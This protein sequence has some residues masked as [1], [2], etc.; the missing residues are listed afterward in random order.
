MAKGFFRVLV[1]LSLAGAAGRKKLNGIHRFL[2]EGYDW[3]MELVRDEADFTEEVL[4]NA[5]REGFNGVFVGFGER[6]EMKR[7]HEKTG[8]PTVFIGQPDAQVMK[9]LPLCLFVNDDH[10]AIMRLAMRHLRSCRGMRTLGFVPSRTPSKWSDARRDAFKAAMRGDERRM[11]VYDG[12]GDSREAL[13]RWLMELEKPAGIVAALDDRAHDVTEACRSL[14]IKVP[15]DVSVLGIGNDEPVCETTV[16]ALS[17]V[18]VDFELEGYRAARELQAMMLRPAT[19][20]ARTILCG[21]HEVVSR[22]STT[23]SR[24]PTALVRRAMEF[25]DRH[26]LEGISAADVVGHLRVSRSLADLRF[27]KVSGTSI[28]EAILDRRIGEVGRLLRETD[29]RISEIAVRCGYRDA[30]YLKNLFKKR[31]GMTMR[32]WRSSGIPLG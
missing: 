23:A 8:I 6:P 25:I 1:A 32:E 3:D 16:P 4:E 10:N 2:G 19:P 17:S 9:R 30:N 29:L 26:A 12:S 28:Q 18:A 13:G 5:A 27:R 7:I 14:S 22:A 15:D 20:T 24:T 21:A 31:F 11:A